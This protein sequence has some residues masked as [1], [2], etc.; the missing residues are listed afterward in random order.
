[1]AGTWKH[2]L[3]QIVVKNS[4]ARKTQWEATEMWIVSRELGGPG[5]E[6]YGREDTPTVRD[7]HL[8]CDAVRILLDA[9]LQSVTG[10]NN[11]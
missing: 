1:M 8:C 4:V 7:Q 6:A 11:G 10:T 3:A 5:A 9:A 2:V